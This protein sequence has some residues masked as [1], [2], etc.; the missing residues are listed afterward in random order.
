MGLFTWL[1]TRD[2]DG[3]GRRIVPRK[4]QFERN[5]RIITPGAVAQPRCAPFSKIKLDPIAHSLPTIMLIIAFL[6]IKKKMNQ[7]KTVT[8]LYFWFHEIRTTELL[9]IDV[10]HQWSH[11]N[12]TVF[13][14]TC[15]NWL[16]HTILYTHIT[17][18]YIHYKHT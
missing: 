5:F 14:F 2:S 11:T 13:T 10:S 12:Y 16:S 17:Y 15:E 6:I 7:N 8:Y 18:I 1:T 4:L 3:L 9:N